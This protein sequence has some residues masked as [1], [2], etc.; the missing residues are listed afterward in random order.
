MTEIALHELG[1]ALAL[2]HHSNPDDLMGT[3]VGYEGGG[4]SSC[5]LDGFEA[6]HHW[7]TAS[8]HGGPHTNHIASIIC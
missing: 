7:L 3:K 6:A 8:D 4:P 5:D 1:H 2:G